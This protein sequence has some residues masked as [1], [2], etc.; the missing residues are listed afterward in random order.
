ML[1]KGGEKKMLMLLP[2]V[3]PP[4]AAV[5]MLLGVGLVTPILP[6]PL[7]ILAGSLLLALAF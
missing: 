6:L 7:N 3:G 2:I 1:K 5:A 4:L